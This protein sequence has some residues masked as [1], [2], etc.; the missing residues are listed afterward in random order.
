M[1]LWIFSDLH[2]ELGTTRSFPD[3]RPDADI[4]LM[5]G[6]CTHADK[7]EATVKAFIEKFQMPVVY[8]AGNHEFYGS[9]TRRSSLESDQM[10][11]RLAEKASEDWDHRLYVLD[12]DTI[13]IEGVRFIGA[14]LWVDFLYRLREDVPRSYEAGNQFAR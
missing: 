7:I 11:L 12:E 10:I 13:V 2:E 8:V 1:K 6:D 14:T 9:L 3:R 5:A 4:A